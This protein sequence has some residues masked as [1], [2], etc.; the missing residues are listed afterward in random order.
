MLS[1]AWAP[2]CAEDGAV[3]EYLNQIEQAWRLQLAKFKIDL[4]EHTA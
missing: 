1:A 4:L 3:S 2:D